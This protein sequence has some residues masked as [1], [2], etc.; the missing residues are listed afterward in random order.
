MV[1]SCGAFCWVMRSRVDIA[2]QRWPTSS[3]RIR[4]FLRGSKL[5]FLRESEEGIMFWQ[6]GFRILEEGGRRGW[7]GEGRE[8][9]IMVLNLHLRLV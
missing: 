5:G 4:L 3:W 8:R 2:R 1:R 7:A 9:V 6:E